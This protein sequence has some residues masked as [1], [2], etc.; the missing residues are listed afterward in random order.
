MMSKCLRVSFLGRW[1]PRL[2]LVVAASISEGTASVAQEQILV[3]LFNPTRDDLNGFRGE[4]GDLDVDNAGR[5]YITRRGREPAAPDDE[6]YIFNPDGTYEI[7]LV[8]AGHYG[9]IAGVGVERDGSPVYIA[10]RRS[11]VRIPGF[12]D[13]PLPFTDP[14]G[15]AGDL[16]L[17][18]DGNVY[19]SVNVGTT[20]LKFGPT[21]QLLDT[22]DVPLDSGI[23]SGMA[24]SPAGDIFVGEFARRQM[25][26]VTHAA[27]LTTFTPFEGQGSFPISGVAFNPV[28]NEVLAATED[29]TETSQLLRFNPANGMLLG[30][31]AIEGT[32][33]GLT[34]DDY[35]SIYAVIGD[36]PSGNLVTPYVLGIDP[37]ITASQLKDAASALILPG[38][39]FDDSP[40]GAYFRG[41]A[42]RAARTRNNLNSIS[43]AQSQLEEFR[44]RA[45]IDVG[46]NQDPDAMSMAIEQV[47]GFLTAVKENS[48]LVVGE[49]QV[50]PTAPDVAPTPPH[51]LYDILDALLADDPFYGR[52]HATQPIGFPPPAH[53]ELAIDPATATSNAIKPGIWGR[54]DPVRPDVISSTVNLDFNG[55]VPSVNQFS[56]VL[57]SFDINGTPSGLNRGRLSPSGQLF[58]QFGRQGR[59]FDAHVEGWITNDLY[60]ESRPIFTFLDLKGF[61][62]GG[63]EATIY[64]TNEP[65]IVPG[66]P[67]EL[68]TNLAGIGFVATRAE[69]DRTTGTLE[70]HE[71]TDPS[72]TPDISV[73]LTPEGV[74]AHGVG[75]GEPAVGAGFS[76]TPLLFTG[77]NA[78]SG[79]YEFADAL[80]TIA[81]GTDLLT[82]ATLT[83]IGID[84]DTL[85]FTGDLDFLVP[86]VGFDSP[87]VN[88]LHGGPAE[89]LL[90]TPS[91]TL[92]LLTRTANFT[93]SG[94]TQTDFIVL[95]VVPEPTGIPL[96][97]TAL[98]AMLAISRRQ[99]C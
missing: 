46:A 82:S 88:T 15:T 40:E 77:F 99:P 7:T 26:R 89:I 50:E 33:F 11:L 47:N 48:P 42:G 80:L 2:I 6:V 60:T 63:S 44:F 35:G 43:E 13:F 38:L 28:T 65:V 18:A 61:L 30:S 62:P 59:D 91:G 92:E 12:D 20:I 72:K 64:G 27:G 3:N 37:T 83:D 23:I 4:F 85:I 17:D 24:V 96:C 69:F 34:V 8:S 36:I 29:G 66:L 90:L 22:I 32:V 84:P 45:N 74:F 53:V 25:G 76:L 57:G 87:F 10:D 97:A 56:M 55:L 41:L 86:Q 79:R 78:A 14:N 49:G 68:P 81:H 73:I 94:M 98:C 70:F 39:S 16:D 95:G 19:V 51:P 54:G 93:R 52:Y 21:G 5:L 31:T 9:L 67:G 71:N 1:L 75:A 58:S